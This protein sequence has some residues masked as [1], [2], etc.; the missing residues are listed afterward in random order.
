[1]LLLFVEIPVRREH[2]GAQWSPG[3]AAECK[4]ANHCW[5]SFNNSA[6]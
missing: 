3:A 6:T 4:L 1:M 5:C 2:L